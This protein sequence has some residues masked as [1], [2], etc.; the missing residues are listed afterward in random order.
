MTVRGPGLLRRLVLAAPLL[1]AA[2]PSR[3]DDATA[4]PGFDELSLQ[5]LLDLSVDV[6][7]AGAGKESLR[8]APAVVEVV[9]AADID[10]WGYRSVGEAIG[11]IVGFYFIDDHIVPDLAV[12]GVAGGLG[13]EAGI[14][15]VLV[16]G[17]AVSFRPSSGAWLGLEL[18]P[19]TA[20][21]RI[22]IIRGPA[23]AMY[24][25][26]AFLGV[27]NVVTHG[28]GRRGL[29]QVRVLAGRQ[30]DAWGRAFDGTLHAHRGGWG[31]LVGFAHERADRSGLAVPGS[32]PAPDRPDHNQNAT[33][34]RGLARSST[35]AY[36]RL[37][38][39]SERA[40]GLRGVT[41]TGHYSQLLRGGDFSQWSHL[42]QGVDDAGRGS[43][44][45]ISLA[46]L[47]LAA[48]SVWRLHERL[49]AEV[50]AGYFQGGSRDDERIEVNSDLFYVRRNLAFRGFDAKAELA[51][52]AAGE[53]GA[54]LGLEALH[55]DED[56]SN[57]SRVLKA[58]GAVLQ[59]ARAPR[60]TLGN[61]AA[62]LETHWRPLAGKLRLTGGL[63]LDES[64][65][66]GPQLTGRLAAVLALADELVL[67]LLYGSAYKAPSPQLLYAT[68]IQPGGLVG[69]ERLRPQ[70]VHTLEAHASYGFGQYFNLTSGVAYQ[71]VVDKAEFVAQGTNQTAKN[72]AGVESV[73]WESRFDLVVR[74]V[75]RGYLSL[76][77]SRTVRELGHRDYLAHVVADKG[78]DSP[79]WIVRAG[80]SRRFRASERFSLQLGSEA[81][82]VGARDA[83]DSNSLERGAL[84]RLPGYADL[85]ASL[86]VVQLYLVPGHETAISLRGRDLLGRATADPGHGGI[87]YPRVG[88]EVF[89]DL[90]QEF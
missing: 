88:R 74:D 73:S 48:S 59:P 1:A 50:A 35:S 60:R 49:D 37:D 10:R 11:H 41:V 31:A 52:N 14:V 81:R 44:T 33:V 7:T 6:A 36:A 69:N 43:G 71:R 29:G 34:A 89:L 47:S 83:S 65:I 15:K 26:D 55:D 56:L 90:R 76:E 85:G 19:L 9:S 54:A 87:D 2:G 8:L 67:K 20:V 22:E 75:A 25:A 42:S 46:Q 66:Y 78:G 30:A 58:T 82:L 57:P 27:V 38:Y 3:A 40:R 16:D 28:P 79:G 39:A 23:S 61:L 77:L 32:S 64:S 21:D 84:Y 5:G 18:V 12:R 72:I 68:P 51:W 4:S 70:L 53:F 63:R 24:G 80:A 86:S 17:R 62:Y 45:T 13:G